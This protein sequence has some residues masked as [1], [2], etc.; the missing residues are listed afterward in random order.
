MEAHTCPPFCEAECYT[1]HDE[2]LLALVNCPDDDITV[3]Y[4]EKLQNLIKEKQVLL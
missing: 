1:I 3:E 4:Q 2:L